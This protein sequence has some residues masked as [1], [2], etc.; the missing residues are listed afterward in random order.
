MR[1]V[2]CHYVSAQGLRTPSIPEPEQPRLRSE[3]NMDNLNRAGLAIGRAPFWR[4]IARAP[5][6]F[7]RALVKVYR[8][9]LSPLVGFHCRH[10]PTCSE[11]ADVALERFGLWAGSWRWLARS[12]RHIAAGT[13]AGAGMRS[14]AVFS[15]RFLASHLA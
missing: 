2:L 11:Y 9:T 10:L 13:L 7:G 1:A 4:S 14:A 12:R 5:R 8:Y 3:D 6:L 15:L